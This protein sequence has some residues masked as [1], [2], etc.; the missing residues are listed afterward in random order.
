MSVEANENARGIHVDLKKFGQFEE[1]LERMKNLLSGI[2]GFS[3]N[4][5]EEMTFSL[6]AFSLDEK[7]G[8]GH[9]FA[10]GERFYEMRI[11]V[12]HSLLDRNADENILSVRQ[13]G[14]AQQS[15]FL[16]HVMSRDVVDHLPEALQKWKVEP[17]DVMGR[18]GSVFENKAQYDFSFRCEPA[19]F[20]EAFAF[21]VYKKVDSLMQIEKSRIPA[22][23]RKPRQASVLAP[24]V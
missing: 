8:S 2:Y 22:Q 13:R 24:R 10:D 19:V 7:H 18:G 6:R 12:P 16:L 11:S 4:A 15:L 1:K 14:S 9:I 20:A 17:T 21:L 5:L 23:P 3:R